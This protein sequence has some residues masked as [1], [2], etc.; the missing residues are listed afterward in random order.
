MEKMD[1][2][3]EILELTEEELDEI[4]AEED[5]PAVEDGSGIPEY[6]FSN[7]A[8]MPRSSHAPLTRRH[9][10]FIL[11]RKEISL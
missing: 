1:K 7:P 2:G 5:C 11:T 9:T 10:I 3:D 4:E 8:P 6:Y